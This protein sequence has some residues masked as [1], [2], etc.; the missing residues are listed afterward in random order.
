MSGATKIKGKAA[1]ARSATGFQVR[2]H[3]RKSDQFGIANP[4][5][6]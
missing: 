4:R 3:E 6:W 5:V 2:Q 1:P